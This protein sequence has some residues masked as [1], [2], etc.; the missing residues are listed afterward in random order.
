MQLML[1][2]INQYKLYNY[3][4]VVNNASIINFIYKPLARL[5]LRL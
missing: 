4:F 2:L 3:V 1:T 5:I